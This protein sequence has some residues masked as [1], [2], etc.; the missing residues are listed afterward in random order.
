MLLVCGLENER[1]VKLQMRKSYFEKKKS[2]K[3]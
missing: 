3:G 2:L 1:F